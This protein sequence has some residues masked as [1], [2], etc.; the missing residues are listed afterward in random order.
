MRCIERYGVAKT[1]IVDVASELGVS[2]QTVHRLFET[3]ADLLTAVA[4]MRIEMLASRLR[5]VFRQFDDLED[6][7]VRGTLLS[8]ELGNTDPIIVEIQQKADHTVDQFM[9]RGSPGVQAIMVGVW[10]PLIEKARVAGRLHSTHSTDSI[11]EWIRNVHAMLT[12]RSDYSR[13]QQLSLLSDFLVPS[14]LKHE[15]DPKPTS[16]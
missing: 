7:L 13:S 9:F 16:G 6:A 1:S 11:V 12:I 14:I 8:L 10:G 15:R 5:D 4:D 2:R 3:K